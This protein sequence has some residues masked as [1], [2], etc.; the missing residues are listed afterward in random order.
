LSNYFSVAAYVNL[1][2]LLLNL[3]TSS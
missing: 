2:I 3:T 1:L